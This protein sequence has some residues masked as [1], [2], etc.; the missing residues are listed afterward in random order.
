M[1]LKHKQVLHQRCM[2]QLFPSLSEKIEGT[3][4][5]FAP[6][7]VQSGL[8]SAPTTIFLA[9]HLPNKSVI[10]RDH[11]FSCQ[12]QSAMAERN[13]AYLQTTACDRT[14]SSVSL[15]PEKDNVALSFKTRL[16]PS[17]TDSAS[18]PIATGVSIVRCASLVEWTRTK[19][20]VRFGGRS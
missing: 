2:N 7:V 12:W 14:C 15:N 5:G 17:R 6:R 1:L 9:Q 18:A 4:T 3:L 13:Y 19:S 10:K 11:F 8:Y 20:D 16:P